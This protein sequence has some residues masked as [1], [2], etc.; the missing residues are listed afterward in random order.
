VTADVAVVG[1]GPAGSAAA[2]ALARRGR[3]TVLLDKARFPRDKCCG[4][5]LTTAAVRHLEAAGF[6]PS[7]VPSWQ[8]V[9]EAVIRTCA[10]RQQSFP[11]P[12]GGTFAATARRAELDAA[13]VGLA[14]D[15]GVQLQEGCGVR[16]A[17]LEQDGG[18]IRLE[19]DGPSVQARYVIAADGMWSPLRKAF[20]VADADGYRGD[21]HALRQ[22]FRRVAPAADRLW[23]WFE[24]DLLPGYL[25]S[26]PL[27]GGGANV[28]F[29]VLRSAGRSVGEMGRQW[30]ELLARPHVRAV[31]GPDAEPESPPKTWPIPARIGAT[32]LTAAGGRVLFAGD[33]ARATDVLT[34]EGIAQAFDTAELAAQSVVA[35]G[36]DAPGRAERTYRRQVSAGLGADDRMSRLVARVLAHPSDHW[37]SIAAAST[38]TRAK[39]ARWMFEDYPRALIVTPHRWRRP[40]LTGPPP[41]ARR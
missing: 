6:Q 36:P 23:V 20:G 7:Q 8:P 16:A 10:G 5:G 2:L 39:F 24:P 32:T 37:M 33:A 15:A 31:L 25:W 35:A 19:T 1:A 21:W 22:Y 14:V 13:L 12:D 4:D 29:G 11:L 17:R 34:G 26:F 18:T 41:Y 38:W 40:M 28:G 9:S 27:P 3:Q 30:P